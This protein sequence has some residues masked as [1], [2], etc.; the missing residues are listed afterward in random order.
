MYNEVLG[1]L[2]RGENEEVL[3]KTHC[4]RL[5]LRILS[6]DPFNLDVSSRLDKYFM[7][8]DR[9]LFAT[10]LKRLPFKHKEEIT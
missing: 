6:F 3:E 10:M 5:A 1:A 8:I 7:K 4:Q 9:G 2:Y